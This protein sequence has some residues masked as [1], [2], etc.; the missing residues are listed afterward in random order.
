MTHSRRDLESGRPEPTISV[1]ASLRHDDFAELLTA[2][3]RL[4][5]CFRIEIADDERVSV[6]YPTEGPATEPEAVIPWFAVPRSMTQSALETFERETAAKHPY[7]VII[8]TD[9]SEIKRIDTAEV[10]RA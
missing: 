2:M 7:Y 9:T 8:R 5:R 1:P 10:P 3:G 4:Y 6:T